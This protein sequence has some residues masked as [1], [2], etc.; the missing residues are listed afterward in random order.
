MRTPAV[1]AF[2]GEVL[3]EGQGLDEIN[4]TVWEGEIFALPG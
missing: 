3:R 1:A 2:E 4:L